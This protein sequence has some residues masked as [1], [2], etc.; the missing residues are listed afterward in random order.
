MGKGS[1]SE[2][3]RRA[4]ETLDKSGRIF[5]ALPDD[6]REKYFITSIIMNTTGESRVECIFPKDP[7]H[8][9]MSKINEII[10]EQNKTYIWLQQALEK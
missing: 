9:V 8:A 3:S 6:M 5:P 10:D 7:D 4:A 1:P 2:I